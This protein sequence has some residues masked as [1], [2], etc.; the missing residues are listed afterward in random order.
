MSNLFPDEEI[1][2]LRRELERHN[3][4]YYVEAKPEITDREYDALMTKLIALET[5]HPESYSPNSPSLKVAG[6]PIDGFAQV[7]HRVPML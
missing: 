1:E 5:A 4:L 3:R 7:T 6:E 2:S